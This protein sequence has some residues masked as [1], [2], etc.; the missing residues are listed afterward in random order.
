[1]NQKSIGTR[2]TE[3]RKGKG[4][5]QND[6][7]GK[8]NINI[9]TL[10]RIESDQVQPRPYTLKEILNALDYDYDAFNEVSN[11]TTPKKE[12]VNAKPGFY[13]K[14]GTFIHQNKSIMTKTF[15]LLCSAFAILFITNVAT[16]DRFV[17]PEA[18]S[19]FSNSNEMA[20]F[21]LSP[22]KATKRIKGTWQMKASSDLTVNASK[23][24]YMTFKS[25]GEFSTKN[26]S[27]SYFNSGRYYFTN[28]GKLITIH[29]KYGKQLREVSNYYKYS[30]KKDQLIIRGLYIRPLNNDSYETFR[31]N[32]VWERIK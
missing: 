20:F 11:D 5:T 31:V 18:N 27:G 7:V 23:T 13:D 16:T 32:E 14:V 28:D 17:R 6:V 9:R 22:R 30:I 12:P 8:C 10:Q 4:Y 21:Q 19:E 2:I 15:F 1:M 24:R 3:L 29:Y 26:A 25:N